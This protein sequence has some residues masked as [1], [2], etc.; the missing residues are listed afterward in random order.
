[1]A[2]SQQVHQSFYPTDWP[3]SCYS[4]NGT[5]EKSKRLSS[6]IWSCLV[7]RDKSS[8]SCLLH[9]N[10]M[11]S[12]LSVNDSN[13][14]ALIFWLSVC[15]PAGWI[16]LRQQ[17]LPAP[18]G[19]YWFILNSVCSAGVLACLSIPGCSPG[20]G[21][22]V[23]KHCASL[24]VSTALRSSWSWHVL[25]LPGGVFHSLAE[26][27]HPTAALA[28]LV[29]FSEMRRRSMLDVTVHPSSRIAGVGALRWRAIGRHD[30]R[31]APEIKPCEI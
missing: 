15:I 30:S 25:L 23:W 13:C 9:D 11:H 3:S 20:P 8:S 2:V 10:K 14:S 17:T 5:S 18:V 29:L 26:A 24:T 1:M 21:M 4:Q 28:V 31:D 22:G 16:R 6:L 19:S 12:S 27:L 7:G